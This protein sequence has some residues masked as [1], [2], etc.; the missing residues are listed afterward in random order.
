MVLKKCVTP[1]RHLLQ[2]QSSHKWEIWIKVPRL[3][4]IINAV[5]GGHMDLKNT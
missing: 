5:F 1:V 3:E 4:T 2:C